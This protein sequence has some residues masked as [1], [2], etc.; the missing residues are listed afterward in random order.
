MHRTLSPLLW[1]Y[2]TL[3]GLYMPE[4]LKVVKLLILMGLVF[5]IYIYVVKHIFFLKT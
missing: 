5:Y 1:N 3:Y 2:P 4:I